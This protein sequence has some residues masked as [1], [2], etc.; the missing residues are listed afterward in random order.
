MFHKFD[1]ASGLDEAVAA[2]DGA[3][4]PGLMR[5]EFSGYVLDSSAYRLAALTPSSRFPAAGRGRPAPA[6]GPALP[7]LLESRTFLDGVI[8][9]SPLGAGFR[10]AG[11][12]REPT[13]IWIMR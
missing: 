13:G 11:G 2:M 6:R 10:R 3:V 8:T 4:K 12:V 9:Y 5:L 1:S 7:G